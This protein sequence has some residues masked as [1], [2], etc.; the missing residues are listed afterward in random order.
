F[1]I[2]STEKKVTLNDKNTYLE[3]DFLKERIYIP[4]ERKLAQSNEEA[5]QK[6]LTEKGYIDLNTLKNYSKEQ[7]IWKKF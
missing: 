7:R 4:Y 1:S 3:A 2:F 6:T 5:L